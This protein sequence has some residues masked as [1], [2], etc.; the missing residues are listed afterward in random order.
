MQ[1]E[2]PTK[3]GFQLLYSYI[4]LPLR[5]IYTVEDDGTR[6]GEDLKQGAGQDFT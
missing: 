5:I 3:V 6:E 4:I 1:G 2:Q